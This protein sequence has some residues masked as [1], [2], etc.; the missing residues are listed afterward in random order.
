M[1]GFLSFK[2]SSANWDWP[3]AAILPE[4]EC[5]SGAGERSESRVAGN[6]LDQTAI[7]RVSKKTASITTSVRNRIRDS[8]Q[9]RFRW[10]HQSGGTRSAI[11]ERNSL[12]SC[13]ALKDQEHI[14]SFRGTRHAGF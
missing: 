5:A 13:K 1:S 6:G 8:L 10:V 12:L 11:K 14:R 3:T 7:A 4:M 9:F 2:M